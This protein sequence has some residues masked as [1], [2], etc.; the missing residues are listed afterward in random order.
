MTDPGQESPKQER[1]ATPRW[2]KAFI[3]VAVALA[4]LVVLMLVLGHEPRQH[5]SSPAGAIP[6]QGHSWR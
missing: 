1:P 5:L 3:I 2:V 6:V 4:A